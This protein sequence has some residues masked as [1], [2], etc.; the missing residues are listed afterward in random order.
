MRIQ[1][2][3]GP[4]GTRRAAGALEAEVL[5]ALWAA[6]GPLTPAQLQAAIGTGLAYNTV[7]TILTRLQD[8]GLVARVRHG[9]RSGYRPIKDAAQHAADRMR[10]VLDGGR[11]R[12]EILQRFVTSLSP[13]DELT[14]RRAL[15]ADEGT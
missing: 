2:P 7:H 1:A 9:G 15:G 12:A 10:T 4:T 5:G 13:A 14:L 8:K 6:D 11:D 3:S